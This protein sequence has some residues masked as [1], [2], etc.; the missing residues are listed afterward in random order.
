[1]SFATGTTINIGTGSYRIPTMQMGAGAAERRGISAAGIISAGPSDVDATRYLDEA[2]AFAQQLADGAASLNPP[3]IAIT[4]P[5]LPDQ[6]TLLNV[7]PPSL[8]DVTFSLPDLPPTFSGSVD[9]EGLLPEPFDQDPPALVLGAIPSAEFGP[10]PEAPGVNFD[11]EDP[12]LNL[13]L[14]GRPELMRINVRRFDGVT[15]PEL[16][17]DDTPE[18]DLVA[19]TVREYTPGAE[20]TS[21]LLTALRDE[22]QGRIENGGTGLNPDVENAIW[23]RGREREARAMRDSILDLERMEEMGFDLPPGVYLDA[24]LRINTE[25]AATNMGLSREIMIKQAELELEAIQ[26]ALTIAQ[27]L[28]ADA[29]QYANQIEQRAFDSARYATEAGVAVY[30]ARV[31]AFGEFVNV[32]RAKLQAYEQQIRGE[33]AKVEVY[34]AEVEA[35]RAKAQ[36]NQTRVEEF[37]VLTDAALSAVRVYEAEIGAIQTKAEIERLKV[38]IFGEEVRAYASQVN[39]YTAQ[40]E[41]YRAGVQAETS[42]QDAFRSSVQAYTSQVD[43]AS[44]QIDARIGV[45][46]A[47]LRTNQT[48]WEGYRTQVQTEGD[49]VRAIA[50]KNDAVA[51]MY[52]SE[53]S[54]VG[55]FNEVLARQ[56]SAASQAAINIT[57]VSLAQARANAELF[58]TQRSMV[59]DAAKVGA[60]VAAQ[61]GAAALSANSVSTSYNNSRSISAGFS[62]NQSVAFSQSRSAGTSVSNSTSRSSSSSEVR[63]LSV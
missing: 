49:R 36:I 8:E 3:E 16:P 9:V 27:R 35:E 20:Y 15:I 47:E 4:E 23:D 24:R 25:N 58:M 57:E 14:P 30:N 21:G 2:L 50:A 51:R 1:M 53:A 18:F 38:A 19:P 55:T 5:N 62:D 29:I 45:L 56:W 59:L 60:T 52:Q 11:F 17:V 42:K 44:K 22:L 48:L 46:D 12:Q 40:V 41:G 26:Q 54:A 39:A 28:E 6:P 13:N 32:Y 43:A 33:L 61:L 10:A 37:R 34:Q 31:A 7:D 63:S